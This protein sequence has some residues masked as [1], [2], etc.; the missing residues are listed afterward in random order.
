M[1]RR[2]AAYAH[3][4]LV[5]WMVEWRV[6][7]ERAARVVFEIKQILVK[8][9]LWLPTLL[10]RVINTFLQSTMYIALHFV[11]RTVIKIFVIRNGKLNA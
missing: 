10:I 11:I 1:P 6:R 4:A 8:C 3:L 7:R 5:P 9:M 2:L